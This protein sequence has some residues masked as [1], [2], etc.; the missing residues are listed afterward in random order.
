VLPNKKLKVNISIANV[1]LFAGNIP[2]QR[3]KDEI[4]EEF[5]KVTGQWHAYI[6]YTG[7]CGGTASNVTLGGG[8]SCWSPR[9]RVASPDMLLFPAFTEGLRDVIVYTNPGEPHKKNRGFAFLEY[10]SHKLASAAKRK[11]S[12]GRCRVLGCDII[13]DWADPQEEPDDDIMEKV[14]DIQRCSCCRARDI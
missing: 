13:I 11:L 4:K 3:S 6:N 14:S 5:A 1:R 8:K 9:W 2:K 7:W 10:E 12:S